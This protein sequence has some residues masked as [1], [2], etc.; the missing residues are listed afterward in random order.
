MP[1]FTTKTSACAIALALAM[2]APLPVAAQQ[3]APP[4]SAAPGT[5]SPAPFRQEELEQLVA[6]IALYP[7]ALLAQVLMA[8]T[9]P[10]GAEA[11]LDAPARRCLPPPAGGGDEGKAAPART[12]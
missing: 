8:S 3:P 2:P 5:A 10:I 12:P 1:A 6:P 4:A 9:H 7:D 11:R